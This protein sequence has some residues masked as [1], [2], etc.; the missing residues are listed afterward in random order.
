MSD[1]D[2]SVFNFDNDEEDI[3]PPS[4]KKT[5]KYERASAWTFQD[6]WHCSHSAVGTARIEDRRTNTIQEV[7]RRT[8]QIGTA[9]RKRIKSSSDRV[10]RTDLAQKL[11]RSHSLPTPTLHIRLRERH[12]QTQANKIFQRPRP[13]HR[14]CSKAHQKS[15]IT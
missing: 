6:R 13:S 5:I 3:S 11:T 15:F 10:R 4:P 1:S 2:A 7:K 9:K 14:P 12:S 8:I